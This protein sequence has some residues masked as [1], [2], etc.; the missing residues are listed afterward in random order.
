MKGK[1]AKAPQQISGPSDQA[2]AEKCFDEI[3]AVL[4]KYD[5]GIRVGYDLKNVLDQEAIFSK[6]VVYKNAPKK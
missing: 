2:I 3:V 1:Q 5:C 6:I 4:K